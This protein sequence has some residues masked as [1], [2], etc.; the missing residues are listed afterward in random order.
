MV[1]GNSEE[2]LLASVACDLVSLLAELHGQVEQ[3]L[4]ADDNRHVLQLPEIS[5]YSKNT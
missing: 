2:E 5:P 4:D 3:Y 1:A